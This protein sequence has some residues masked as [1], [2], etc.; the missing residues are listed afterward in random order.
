VF[1]GEATANPNPVAG[2]STVLSALASDDGGEA[3]LTYTWALRDGPAAVTFS[4]N[5]T[6]AAKQTTAGFQAAGTYTF[7]VTARDA[8]GAT[9]TSTVVVQVL[10]TVTT[11]TLPPGVEV[12][13]HGTATFEPTVFD[14]FGHLIA[15]PPPLTWTVSGGGS[16]A[17]GTFMAV[18]TKVRY[19]KRQDGY[20]V[21][22][23]GFINPTEGRTVV[24][25][26][27]VVVTLGSTSTVV[28]LVDLGRGGSDDRRSRFKFR[29]RTAAISLLTLQNGS[30]RFKMKTKALADTALMLA[31]DED[32]GRTADLPLTVEI[33]LGDGLTRFTTIVELVR[34]HAGTATWSRP[35]QVP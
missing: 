14:Q 21:R 16:I 6:N 13:L 17:D 34:P 28:P 5:G 32:T 10:Q 35:G 7:R 23:A 33:P 2:T 20:V 8:S 4:L 12:R 24:P 29:S 9:A 18:R 26:G 19:S 27:D 30:Q 15:D 11:I 1:V 3:A 31:P 25:R 22:T